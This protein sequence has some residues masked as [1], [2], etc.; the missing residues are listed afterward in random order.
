MK[1]EDVMKV[2]VGIGIGVIF[3][4]ILVAILAGNREQKPRPNLRPNLPQIPLQQGI[5]SAEYW[6]N[7]WQE[8]DRI[9]AEREKAA[10]IREQNRI[11]QQQ[12]EDQRLRYY[13]GRRW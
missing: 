1:R 12:L 9:Q 10:A 5:G 6:L 8:D 7:R 13:T 3:T 11:L 4:L 2:S